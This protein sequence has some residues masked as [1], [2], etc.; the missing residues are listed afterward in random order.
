MRAL[1]IISTI[2]SALTTAYC[3]FEYQMPH[4]QLS[5]VLSELQQAAVN[6]P[7]RLERIRWAILGVQTTWKPLLVLASLQSILMIGVTVYSCARYEK[8]KGTA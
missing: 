7:E 8:T 5:K 1:L 6:D 3:F 2:L 4:A